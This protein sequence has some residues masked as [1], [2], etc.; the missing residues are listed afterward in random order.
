MGIN[1]KYQLTENFEIE[2]YDT[3]VNANNWRIGG[4]I[5]IMF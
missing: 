1:A 4:Q 5:G 3:D 2:D